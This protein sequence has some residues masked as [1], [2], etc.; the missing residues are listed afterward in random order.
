MTLAKGRSATMI[1]VTAAFLV[2]SASIGQARTFGCASGDIQCLISSITEAN[3]NGREKNTIRLEAGTYT[4]VAVDNTTDGPNGLPSI[5]ST[6]TIVADGTGASIV[7][8]ASAPSFRIFHVGSAGRLTLKQLSVIGGNVNNAADVN[9]GSGGGLFNSGGEV[10]IRSSAFESNSADTGA[11]GLSNNGGSVTITSTSFL[12]NSSGTGTGGMTTSGD[13]ATISECTFDQNFGLGSGAI[14]VSGGGML[15]ISR[16]QF[17]NNGA[18]FNTG[19]MWVA[20]GYASVDRT[21]FFNNQSG[22]NGAVRVD[23]N[24][25]SV[26]TNSAFVENK[27]AIAIFGNFGTSEIT[28]TTFARNENYGNLSP[29]GIALLDG[30]TMLLT[31]ST[32]SENTVLYDVRP[33]PIISGGSRTFIGNVI[34]AHRPDETSVSTC[35]GAITSLGNNILSDQS[36]AVALLPSDIVGDPG[37][38]PFTDDGAPG[39][40]HYP[41]L[42]DSLAID[43][44]NPT[45]CTKKDQIGDP[46]KRACDIGA[47]EFL[48]AGRPR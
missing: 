20:S 24:G 30:G 15:Q 7:R 12:R 23:T 45:L 17:T 48:T 47:I 25:V 14:Q 27:S 10:T 29:S 46:R 37:L 6:L 36:C 4:L 33:Y 26:I 28:N 39:N 5:T 31:N 9:A 40:A 16:T 38:G 18:E 41:L 35:P 32:F 44:G 8:D 19:G 13:Q 3:T 34:I 11:G 1:T 42:P 22:G 43:A 21:T 2:L